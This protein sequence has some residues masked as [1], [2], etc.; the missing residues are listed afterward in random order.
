VH[1]DLKKTG[2]FTGRVAFLNR[3]HIAHSPLIEFGLPACAAD[4]AL[5]GVIPPTWAYS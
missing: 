4:K 5:Q 1:P 3:A 2:F